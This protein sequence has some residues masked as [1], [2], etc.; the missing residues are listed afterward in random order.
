[1]IG[2]FT[3]LDAFPKVYAMIRLA[4]LLIGFVG[5]GPSSSENLPL[6]GVTNDTVA[7]LAAAFEH[8]FEEMV[9]DSA[10]LNIEQDDAD[11][12]AVGIRL[13]KQLAVQVDVPTARRSEVHWCESEVRFPRR[14]KLR[15]LKRLITVQLDRVEDDRAVVTVSAWHEWRDGRVDIE[16]AQYLLRMSDGTWIVVEQIMQFAS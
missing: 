12:S 7:V 1:M 6:P 5:C 9:L 2:E 10:A 11:A 14:C 4:V 8:H 13:L 16:G 15:D 3:S